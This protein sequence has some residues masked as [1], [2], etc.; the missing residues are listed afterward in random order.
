MDMFKGPCADE[1]GPLNK[2]AA[3]ILAY[4]HNRKYLVKGNLDK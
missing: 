2:H 1:E 4:R 3:A